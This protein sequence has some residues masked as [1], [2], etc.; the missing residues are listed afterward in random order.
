MPPK[1][2][3]VTDV[4]A[5]AARIMEAICDQLGTELRR[6]VWFT[7]YASQ[8]EG[9]APYSHVADVAHD[10][11]ALMTKRRASKRA[12][13]DWGANPWDWHG[14]AEKVAEQ[15][16]THGADFVNYHYRSEQVNLYLVS[17]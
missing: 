12:P 1:K 16:V 11:E 17:G 10:L 9:L 7:V 6:A 3:D 2:P 13:E 14:T 15:F 4:A 8:A 5:L